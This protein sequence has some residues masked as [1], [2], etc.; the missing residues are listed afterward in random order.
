MI[1][2]N[3]VTIEQLATREIE[4]IERKRGVIARLASAETAA[5]LAAVVGEAE[6]EIA[7]VMRIKTETA[8]VDLAIKTVRAQRGPVVLE[9]NRKKISE[10]R[11]QIA[12]KTKERDSLNTKTRKVLDEL[13]RLQGVPYDMDLIDM[14]A[15]SEL[16]IG[17]GCLQTK[18]DAL[19]CEILA[20]EAKVAALEGSSFPP[21]GEVDIETTD[22]LEAVRAVLNH[23]SD[24]PSMEAVQKWI[25]DCA[26]N[27]KGLFPNGFGV[28]QR[29]IKLVWRNGVILPESYI[30]VPGVTERFVGNY[31]EYVSPLTG[32]FQAAKAA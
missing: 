11:D 16:G 32:T 2:G 10:L 18:T 27:G 9:A 29:R 30:Y 31:G 20:L 6:G 28:A 8:A 23:P 15:G 13:G 21:N 14:Q 7:A 25:A 5:G 17:N 26:R 24:G 1:F 19:T 4:L 12:T 22:D 3:T